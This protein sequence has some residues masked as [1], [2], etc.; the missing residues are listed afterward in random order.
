MVRLDGLREMDAGAAFFN[1][2]IRESSFLFMPSQMY[3]G[4]MSP[5][6]H[7]SNVTVAKHIEKFVR[8]RDKLFKDWNLFF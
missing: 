5:G 4:K 1:L 2:T 6:S 7:A 3:A 8:N